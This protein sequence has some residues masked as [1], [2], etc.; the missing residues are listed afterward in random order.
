MVALS[1]FR[2][3]RA[4]AY[5]P[6]YPCRGTPDPGTYSGSRS[7][8]RSTPAGVLDDP[9]HDPDIGVPL[10]FFAHRRMI[11]IDDPDHFLYSLPAGKNTSG[12]DPAAAVAPPSYP[13]RTPGT[14]RI[15]DDPDHVCEKATRAST[16]RKAASRSGPE[17]WGKC[18]GS[19][20]PRALYM[21]PRVL[22]R[23]S[24]ALNCTIR[25]MIRS[26]PDTARK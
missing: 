4:R 21:A 14:I 18:A 11:R 3:L 8:Y 9:D 1:R 22:K 2:P 5:D 13:V 17:F 15:I 25:I 16:I 12:S 24:R 10:F 20:A 19:T 7:G 6:E 26:T 23:A